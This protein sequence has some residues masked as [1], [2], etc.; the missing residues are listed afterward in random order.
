MPFSDF[1][2]RQDGSLYGL[3]GE[4]LL[5]FEGSGLESWWTIEFPKAANRQGLDD[6]TDVLITFDVTSSYAPELYETHVQNAPR[7]PAAS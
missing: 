6:I 2:I 1:N 3:A 4:T 7:R 5:N